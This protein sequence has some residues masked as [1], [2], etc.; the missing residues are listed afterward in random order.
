MTTASVSAV[1]SPMA[2]VFTTA[3]AVAFKREELDRL[4]LL[5]LV[6]AGGGVLVVLEVWS[7][8]GDSWTG[9][10]ALG[11]LVIILNCF[12]SALMVIVQ[13]AIGTD[14]RLKQLF[15][16]M[17]MSNTVSWPALCIGAAVQFKLEVPCGGA[18]CV[19]MAEAAIWMDDSF[20]PPRRCA[21]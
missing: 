16:C 17:A 1:L 11:N 6:L 2:M 19:T 10:A 18:A 21:R 5:G 13:T 20:Q 3:L 9:Q 7:G 15:Y 14:Q 12:L 4:K 8:S